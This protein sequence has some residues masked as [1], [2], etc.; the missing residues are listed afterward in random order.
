MI[1]AC[2]DAIYGIDKLDKFRRLAVARM[3]DLHGEVGVDV[4]GIAAENDDAVREDD[5]FFDV[6]SNDENGARRNF[7]LEPE[8][9][10]FAPQRFR[11]ED[12][13]RRERFV[14]EENFRL[15][16]QRAGDTDALL[17]AARKFLRVGGLET[18]EAYGVN[19][20][21]S[22]FVALDG[23]H[24]AS[25]EGSLDIF[26]DRE[27]GKKRETLE[28]DGDIRRLALHRLAVPI[29]CARGSGR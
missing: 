9:E 29:Y 1:G 3:R 4:R 22:A 27:P 7:V 26:D 16:H 11:G 21:Q 12:V 23:G 5:G 24:A 28:N 17:H 18:V 20:A 25:F 19:D 13:E 6:V 8:F 14:H 15:D 2:Q 10:K